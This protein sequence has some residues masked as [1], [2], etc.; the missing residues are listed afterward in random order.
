MTFW[1]TLSGRSLL[2]SVA[3]ALIGGGVSTFMHGVDAIVLLDVALFLPLTINVFGLPHAAE[4][5]PHEVVGSL[6]ALPLG[7]WVFA[8]SI[9]FYGPTTPV[10]AYLSIA[11]GV[12]S[13]AWGLRPA[14]PALA[15]A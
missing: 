15:R 5:Y 10:L 9:A 1:Q 11:L 2:V 3:I 8:F 12:A 13:L 4:K 14:A 6:V 7:M